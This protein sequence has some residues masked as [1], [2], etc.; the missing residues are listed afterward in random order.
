MSVCSGQCCTS[1]DPIEEHHDNLRNEIFV[2]LDIGDEGPSAHVF[3]DKDDCKQAIG[4]WCIVRYDSVLYPGSIMDYD[5]YDDTLLVR[6]LRPIGENKF[7]YPPRTDETWYHRETL[8]MLIDEPQKPTSRSRFVSVEPRV[9]KAA[10][11]K[12]R[13]FGKN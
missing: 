5:E 8:V 2:T 3:R 1:S 4:K 6:A 13:E 10:N 7:I 12:E 9:W 11:G